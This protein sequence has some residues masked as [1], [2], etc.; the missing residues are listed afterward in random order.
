[1]KQS[2]ELTKHGSTPLDNRLV[3][4]APM[5]QLD[6]V[7]WDQFPKLRK[8]GSSPLVLQLEL[9]WLMNPFP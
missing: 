4:F 5:L 6:L 2:S 1:M 8:H 9:D 7:W 3:E